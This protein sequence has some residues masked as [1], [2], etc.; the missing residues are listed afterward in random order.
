MKEFRDLFAEWQ[1]TSGF[2]FNASNGPSKEQL[3]SMN[4]EE[5]EIACMGFYLEIFPTHRTAKNEFRCGDLNWA[6][7]TAEGAEEREKKGEEL[8]GREPPK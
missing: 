4:D 3:A 2:N 7:E 6:Y 8:F 5:Q 1:Q